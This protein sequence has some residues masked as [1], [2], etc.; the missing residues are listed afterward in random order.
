MDAKQSI[1]DDPVELVRQLD[2]EAIRNRLD[3][4]DREREALRVLLR[5]AQRAQRHDRKE[6][7]THG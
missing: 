4:L 1:P 2:A 3:D 5:V 7:H 6:G